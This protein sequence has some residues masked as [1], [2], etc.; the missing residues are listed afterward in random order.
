MRVTWL[1]LGVMACNGPGSCAQR[2]ALTHP[3]TVSCSSSGQSGGDQPEYAP[4]TGEGWDPE[5][6]G[7]YWYSDTGGDTF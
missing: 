6:T 2:Y 1:M 7:Y 5:D 4:D 3:Q